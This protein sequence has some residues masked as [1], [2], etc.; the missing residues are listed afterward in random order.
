MSVSVPILALTQIR[1]ILSHIWILCP[2][3]G[4]ENQRAQASYQEHCP[5]VMQS[6]VYAS[7]VRPSVCLSVPERAHSSKPAAAGVL[8]WARSVKKH[9]TLKTYFCHPWFGVESLVDP[10]NRVVGT[11]IPR[12]KGAIFFGGGDD[13]HTMRPCGFAA[14][15]PVCR[16]YRSVAARRSAAR[17]A[18]DECG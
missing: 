1:G 10:R 3:N 7:V 17:H 2:Q 18:A 11:Q 5:H 16:R 4:D 8:L 14:V 15:G 12:A 9:K 6:R 13:P